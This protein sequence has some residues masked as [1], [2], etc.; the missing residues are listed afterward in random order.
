MLSPTPLSLLCALL[1]CLPLAIIFTITTPSSSTPSTRSAT[2]CLQTSAPTST[3]GANKSA[4]VRP[5]SALL[6]AVKTLKK[7]HNKNTTAAATDT[8]SSSSSSSSS[9]SLSQAATVR[10]GAAP[11]ET[12]EDDNS[13]L[14]RVNPNPK[15]PLKKLAFMFL[16][17]TP[18]PFEPLW[19]L[20]FNNTPK[21]LYNIYIH[22]DPSFNYTTPPFRGVFARR[23]IPSKPTRR[24]SPTLIAAARRL[25]S[26]ALLDDASNYMFAL[27][28]PSCIPLRS[29]K[30]T[31][32]ILI[33]SKKSFIEIL[34]D[35]P[36]AYERWA[37]RGE[38][39]MEPEVKFEDFRI[40]SQFW[41]LKRKHARIVARD[42]RLW[43][44]F[45]LPC[46]SPDTCYPEEHYFPTL[47]RKADPQ[48]CVPATLTHVDWRGGYGGHPRTYFEEE[49]GPE[50]I[51]ALRK[52]KPRYGTEGS[53]ASDWSGSVRRRRD[54]FLFARKFSPTCVGPLMDI[55]NDIIF[56]D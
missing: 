21:Y 1:L 34:K 3:T 12:D 17:T 56:R 49:V 9:P 18:L 8:V 28:S 54:P 35:E 27:L 26:R 20:F 4:T 37:A 19:E 42:R 53:N 51:R 23:V 29:F 38:E 43:S 22:A 44:K 24:H 55:A 25:L 47:L 2:S 32:R 36:G 31:Y 45:K 10:G 15:P 14:L 5:L 13:Q 7:P 52:A 50:M 39:V 33:K 30:S 16:T 11:N 46:L 6:P 48:G 41:V 40:G